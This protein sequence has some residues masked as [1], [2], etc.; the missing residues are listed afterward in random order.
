MKKV[1]LPAAGLAALAGAAA[2]ILHHIRK[3]RDDCEKWAVR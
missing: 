1:I 3:N 2:L